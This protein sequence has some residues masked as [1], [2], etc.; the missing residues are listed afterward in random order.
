MMSK[1]GAMEIGGIT[2]TMVALGETLI[3]HDLEKRK[4]EKKKVV[5]YWM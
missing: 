4:R 1:Q 5:Y 3:A 2:F